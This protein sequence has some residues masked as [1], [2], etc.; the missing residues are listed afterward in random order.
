LSSERCDER[1]F[2][3]SKAASL[4]GWRRSDPSAASCRARAYGRW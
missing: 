3:R 2:N 1:F 4:E